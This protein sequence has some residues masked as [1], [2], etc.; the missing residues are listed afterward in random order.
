LGEQRVSIIPN[1]WA[2][3]YSP[4]VVSSPLPSALCLN[5]TPAQGMSVLVPAPVTLPGTSILNPNSE[6]KSVGTASRGFSWSLKKEVWLRSTHSQLPF[7]PCTGGISGN[8]FH[9]LVSFSVESRIFR[10]ATF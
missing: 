1:T 7:W 2:C 4:Q 10:V 6:Y 5:F 8:L 3:K 9:V